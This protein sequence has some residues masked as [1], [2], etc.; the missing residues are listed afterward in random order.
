VASSSGTMLLVVLGL[1]AIGSAAQDDGPS[2]ED[3][4]ATDDFSYAPDPDASSSSGWDESSC[5][6]AVAATSGT[7]TIEIPGD[8]EILSSSTDL[9]CVVDESSADEAVTVL[10]DALV[11]CHGQWVTVDGE[12][13]PQTTTAVA[14]VQREHGLTADGVYGP[15]TLRVMQWPQADA[16]D[17]TP[18]VAAPAVA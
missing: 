6:D 5:D 2:V 7:V 10:Q 17:G 8:D 1:A 11:R 3:E 4:P 13:G 14:N 16:P 12:Y 18:C 15:A 9:D